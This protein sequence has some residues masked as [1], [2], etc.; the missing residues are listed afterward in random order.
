M[1]LH[2]SINREIYGHVVRAPG[3][4]QYIPRLCI[5][6]EYIHWLHVTDE[7]IFIFFSTDEYSS[8]YSW[9]LYSSVA[10]SVNRGI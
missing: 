1:T 8:I 6:E 9:A 4:S 7:Y 10:L 2:S 5:T 3:G